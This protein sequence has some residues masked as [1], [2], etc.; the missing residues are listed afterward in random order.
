[1]G[2]PASS[3]TEALMTSHEHDVLVCAEGIFLRS[4]GNSK[5]REIILQYRTAYEMYSE[6]QQRIALDVLWTIHGRGG[7]FLSFYGQTFVIVHDE[8]AVGFVKGCFTALAAS[9]R[10][11]DE[12]TALQALS[13]VLPAENGISAAFDSATYRYL[14]LQ[15]AIEASRSMHE[16][17]SDLCQQLVLADRQYTITQSVVGLLQLPP[18][19]ESNDPVVQTMRHV[20]EIYLEILPLLN[21][22]EGPRF[23]EEDLVLLLQAQALADASNDMVQLGQIQQIL[24]NVLQ[25]GFRHDLRTDS[26]TYIRANLLNLHVMLQRN[27]QTLGD[28]DSPE[29]PLVVSSSGGTE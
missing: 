2:T 5:L 17:V 10:W 16:I 18:G 15:Q 1:M 14:S 6:D 12:Q 25:N 8:V 28:T 19:A 4:S 20:P 21:H 29:P 26:L 13:L 23:S 22:P 11:I 24:S 27:L 9:M 3:I 7:R